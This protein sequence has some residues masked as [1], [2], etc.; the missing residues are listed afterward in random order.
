MY[1]WQAAQR[2]LVE[3]DVPIVTEYGLY[4][5][6]SRVLRQGP[7]ESMPIKPF[8]RVW[9]RARCRKLI[10]DLERRSILVRDAD[11]ASGVW[12]V[13][14]G[15]RSA[16]AEEAI[17]IVDPFAYVSHLSAMQ[18]Y[19]LTNRAPTELHLTTPAP[20]IWAQMRNERI[21]QDLGSDAGLIDAPPLNRA[22]MSGDTV[23]RRPV[24]LHTTVHPAHPAPIAGSFARV[25]PIGCVFADML[26]A[27]EQ[28]GGI[29]HALEIWESEAADW[30]DEI[31]EAVDVHPTK[32]AKVRA[33]YV[34]TERLGIE[35]ERIR[36]WQAFAQRGGSQKLDPE[37][38]YVPRWSDVWMIS[39]NV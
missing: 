8:P 29:R 6:M 25:A 31:V 34:F 28:C 4:V 13:A 1:L 19:G 5:L 3:A 14:Q 37:A 39:L 35:N 32:L 24:R 16:S 30:L 7:V 36:A 26:A 23:R 21:V 10:S 22:S 12:R 20:P 38:P 18:L 27:P 11:F 33:G 17:C 2:T 15:T 9:H